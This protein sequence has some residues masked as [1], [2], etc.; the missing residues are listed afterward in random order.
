MLYHQ[1]FQQLTLAS[2]LLPVWVFDNVCLVVGIG[3]GWDVGI[4]RAI[5][6]RLKRKNLRSPYRALKM[7]KRMNN[8]CILSL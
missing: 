5:G 4:L 8:K 6:I 3:W 7:L 2:Q 1:G